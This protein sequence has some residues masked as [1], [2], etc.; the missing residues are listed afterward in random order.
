M[1]FGMSF[2]RA[3]FLLALLAAAVRVNNALRF[4][5]VNGF[6]AA[7]NIEYVKMLLR[8]WRLPAPD[9]AWATAHPPL[10]YYLSAAITRLSLVFDSRLLTEAA[11]PLLG[12]AAGLVT[13]GLAFVLVRRLAPD[14]PRRA[15]LAAALLFFLPVHIYTSAMLNEEMLASM[16]VSLA[17]FA[18]LR[19]QERRDFAS[20][21]LAGF[22]GGLAVLTKLSGALVL[23][24]A[25]ASFALDGLRRRELGPALARVALLLSVAAVVGGWFYLRNLVAY[26]YLYP[27]GLSVHA[28]MFEM[29]PGE[30]SVL[31]YLRL[32]L[33]TLLEPQL[34]HADLLHSVW[35]ST[36]ATLWFDGHRHFLPNSAAAMT[37][38]R[39]L[40]V[41]ALLPTAALFIGLAR[42]VRR[43][44]RQP[45]GPD[46]PLL[47]LVA[48]S[49]AGY[50]FFTWQNPWFATVKASY[51]LGLSIPFAVYTSEVLAGWTRAP[52]VRGWIVWGMLGTLWAAVVV[53]FTIG[54]VFVK[55]DGA[56]LPWNGLSTHG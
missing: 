40:L 28:V 41:L 33:A 3:G 56:G 39:V 50:V 18:V 34:L 22:L 51:L 19:C 29:P 27:H 20:A 46:L 7:E 14:D 10:F 52:G 55:L 42:G 36:Y 44:L 5:S 26:G 30:R 54:P 35:G 6:D 37:A 11:I 13:A 1:R 24:A 8:S 38:G 43:C 32:P 12:S 47:L 15:T 48:A 23:A 31:D 45:F 17:L 49:L 53:V 2:F 9:A 21:A 25:A 4:R 16:W